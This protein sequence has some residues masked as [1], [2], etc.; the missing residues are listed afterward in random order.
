[1]YNKTKHV[2]V[3]KTNSDCWKKNNRITICL[4]TESGTWSTPESFWN[5]FISRH[6]RF[7]S[8]DPRWNNWP[9]QF[10]RNKNQRYQ[11]YIFVTFCTDLYFINGNCSAKNHEQEK[12][13]DNWR[14]YQHLNV[15]LM[16]SSVVIHC[17]FFIINVTKYSIAI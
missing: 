17:M 11:N 3:N 4:M 16:C 1:M 2:W 10:V 15:I 9:V 14:V 6:D 12:A 7:S 13:M 8:S 5:H